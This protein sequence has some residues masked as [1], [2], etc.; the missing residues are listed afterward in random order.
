MAATLSNYNQNNLKNFSSHQNENSNTNSLLQDH[1]Y[2]ILPVK[3]WYTE[4]HQKISQLEENN[5]K[6]KKHSVMNFG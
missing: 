4:F 5:D 3:Q 2:K 6:D 1:K